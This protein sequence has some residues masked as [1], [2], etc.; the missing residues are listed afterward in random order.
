MQ[1]NELENVVEVT[2][3]LVHDYYAGEY[4]AW[5]QHLDSKS[6]WISSHTPMLIGAKCIREYFEEKEKERKGSICREEYFPFRVNSRVL[7]V[8]AKFSE[9]QNGDESCK[10]LMTMTLIYK[11]MGKGLKLVLQHSTVEKF[12]K[13]YEEKEEF[14]MDFHTFRFVRGLLMDRKLGTCISVP[15]GNRTLFVDLNTVLFIKSNGR[16]T[17]FHCLDRI[18]SCNMP[19]CVISKKL[20]E[21]FYLIH[22]SYM[23]NIRYITAIYRYEAELISGVRVPIPALPYMQIKRDLERML[24]EYPRQVSYSGQRINV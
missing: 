6:V 20:P 18:F 9:K 3:S 16:K 2:K 15:S 17:E 19:M 1:K 22:R 8:I 12:R 4:G 21:N 5:F 7:A 10:N 13:E 23:V 11:N 14:P 24:C